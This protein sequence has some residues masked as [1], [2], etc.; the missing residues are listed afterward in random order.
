MNAHFSPRHWQLMESEKKRS[1]ASG[2]NNH[3]FRFC[4]RVC[5]LQIAVLAW[6]LLFLSFAPSS[7]AQ[8]EVT[9]FWPEIDTYIKIDDN[10]R[11]FFIADQT[12]EDRVGTQAEFGPNID[13]YLKPLFKLKKIAGLQLD[14]SKSRP[15]M[16]R[17][18]YRYMPSPVDPTENRFVL[19]LTP[20]YP[21]VRGILVTDRNRADLRIIQ[22]VFSWRYRNRLSIEREFSVGR[23]RFT[24][25]AR[26]EAFYDSNYNKF[27]RTTEDVGSIFPI[28]KHVEIE[29]YGEHQNDT[30][31]AP[32]RQINAG[33]LVLSLYF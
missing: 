8:N 1:R 22:G 33:S 10:M 32:N 6:I 15:L 16:L 25:Y 26:A 3:S 24:P 30:S 19:E 9:Q 2:N 27:S 21:F 13:F 7:A 12:R 14:E 5:R 23:F 28:G 11:F 20:H 29:A 4:T 17:I 31:K 18:G